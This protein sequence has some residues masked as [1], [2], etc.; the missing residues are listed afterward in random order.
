MNPTNNT[1]S[2]LRH[3]L[4]FLDNGGYRKAIGSRQPLF[5]ME[6]SVEWRQPLF[7]EDSPTCPKKRYDPCPD[8]RCVLMDLVPLEQRCQTVPCHHIPLNEMGETIDHLYRTSP[9]ERVEAAIRAWLVDTIKRLERPD[10]TFSR[11]EAAT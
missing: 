9:R 11:N 2:T 5:C 6:T 4:E 8:S 10:D 7:F 3:E 1:L